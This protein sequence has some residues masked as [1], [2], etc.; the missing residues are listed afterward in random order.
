MCS[1]DRLAVGDLVGLSMSHLWL[2]QLVV[3]CSCVHLNLGFSR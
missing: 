1:T 2:K 3:D